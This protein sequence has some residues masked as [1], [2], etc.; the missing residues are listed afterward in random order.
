MSAGFEPGP[1]G[2]QAAMHT[3]RP[4]RIAVIGL[5]VKV[6]LILPVIL[7][8]YRRH[9]FSVFLGGKC[10]KKPEMAYKT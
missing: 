5:K 3:S 9:K 1:T 2:P 8:N 6:W 7:K 10:H 4:C